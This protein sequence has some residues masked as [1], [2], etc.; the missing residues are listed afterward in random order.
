MIQVYQGWPEAMFQCDAGWHIGE[1]WREVAAKV[2]QFFMAFL[3]QGDFRG[4][5]ILCGDAGSRCK[6]EL[7]T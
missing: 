5:R 1:L 3:R 7:V 4:W 6:D 2:Y